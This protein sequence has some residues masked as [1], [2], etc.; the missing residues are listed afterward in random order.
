MEPSLVLGRPF[1]HLVTIPAMTSEEILGGEGGEEREE[2]ERE[3]GRRGREK[4]E[5]VEGKKGKFSI[6]FPFCILLSSLYISVYPSI[7]HQYI[8][9]YLSIILTYTPTL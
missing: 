5:G 6:V 2:R 3:G 7:S 4:R 8:L 9:V 1:R